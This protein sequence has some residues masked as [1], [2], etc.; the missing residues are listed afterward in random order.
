M[1]I[2]IDN[3]INL[4][5]TVPGAIVNPG[6][7][8]TFALTVP[9]G[10]MGYLYAQATP[11]AGS[12]LVPQISLSDPALVDGYDLGSYL[13]ITSFSNSSETI[14]Y[15]QPVPVGQDST[16]GLL[17]A[18]GG[19]TPG[20]GNLNP[21]FTQFLLPGTYF[22]TVAA[23]GDGTSTGAYT[24]TT[25]FTLA[26]SDPFVSQFNQPQIVTAPGPVAVIAAP[27]R[28]NG[29]TDLVTANDAP[30]GAS[31]TVILGDGDGTFQAA[32]S[33]PIAGP[34]GST[35]NLTD[36]VASDYNNDGRLSL[37]TY[38]AT[39]GIIYVLPGLGDGTFLDTPSSVLTLNAASNP[40]LLAL[41]ASGPQTTALLP[42]GQLPDVNRD[43][44]PDTITLVSQNHNGQAPYTTGLAESFGVPGTVTGNV[45]G[46]VSFLGLFSFPATVSLSYTFSSSFSV[47]ANDGKVPAGIDEQTPLLTNVTGH[48]PGDLAQ[49]EL[50][51]DQSG[52]ILLRQG[53]PDHPGTFEAPLTINDP[54]TDPARAIAVLATGANAR[55]AAIGLQDRIA[56]YSRQLD[57]TWVETPGPT[58]QAS[59]FPSTVIL[60]VDLNQDGIPD[61][62]VP[63]PLLGTVDVYLGRADGTF[64]STPLSFKT[65]ITVSNVTA[66]DVNGDN[67]MDLI[68]TDP[69]SGDVSVLLNQGLS[70][71]QLG[72]QPAV[73]YRAGGSSYG[74]VDNQFASIF[75]TQATSLGFSGFLDPY[76]SQY[77]VYSGEQTIAAATGNFSGPN[78]TDLVT[79]N[80]GTNTIG[81]LLAQPGPQGNLEASYA[82]PLVFSSGGQGPTA[83]VVAPLVKGS[84]QDDV[85][86]LNQ[87]SDSIAVYLGNGQGGFT[88]STPFFTITAGNGATGITVADVNGDGIP[89]L[90]IGNADGDVLTLIGAGDGTFVPLVQ[91]GTDIP[92]AVTPLSATQDDIILANPV[93]NQVA[94]QSGLP[95]NAVTNGSSGTLVST[96][97][98]VFQNAQD[99]IL[100]PGAVQAANLIPGDPYPALIVANSGGN[101]VFVYP[102]TGPGQFDVA[103]AQS[104]AVGTDPVSVTVADVNGD[105]T[106]DL[107]VADKGS[108]DVAILL[109]QGSGSSWTTIKGERLSSGGNGPASTVVKDVNGDGISDILVTNSGSNNVALLPGVGGGFFNDQNPTVF[110]TGPRP[111]QIVAVTTATGS[112]FVV[113]NTGGSTLTELSDFTGGQFST[114][115]N[116]D[117]GGFNPV[118]L[119]AVDLDLPG[120]LP[121]L[122]DLI[123]AD[124]NTGDLFTPATGSDTGNLT[125]LV[126]DDTGFSVEETFTDPNMPNPSAVA[127]S[128][129]DEGVFYATT[130]GV[131]QAFRFQIDLAPPQTVST[132]QPV[133]GS[134]PVAFAPA[135]VPVSAFGPPTVVPV[136]NLAEIAEVLTGSASD[137]GM[138]GSALIGGEAGSNP[139]GI[140]RSL[141]L[142]VSADGGK[143][144]TNDAWRRLLDDL[145]EAHETWAGNVVQQ[146]A[147]AWRGFQESVLDVD[148]GRGALVSNT[149]HL[150]GV[151]E[152]NLPDLQWRADRQSAPGSRRGFGPIHLECHGSRRNGRT[153]PGFR[154]GD[155]FTLAPRREGWTPDRG[156]AP[157]GGARATWQGIGAALPALGA[158]ELPLQDTVDA[159]SRS[160]LETFRLAPSSPAAPR[161]G[162]SRVRS[163]WQAKAGQR[164]SSRYCSWKASAAATGC[165]TAP[166]G[167]S[168]PLCG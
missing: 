61:L 119:V 47:A 135:V 136:T 162:R 98:T 100:A 45:N 144:T 30:G 112:G 68:A 9:A 134:S 39:A 145:D 14:N 56:I 41:F 167:R 35:P 161:P 37:L 3:T 42:N 138:L 123:V 69:A 8:D 113:V 156:S 102:G 147:E 99:G 5:G 166:F 114:D 92:L 31:L 125:L 159:V 124:A 148:S 52:A 110:A 33:Y 79:V 88:T 120:A 27:L 26:A 74:E 55:I 117:A 73:L 6:D 151:N 82:N 127:L 38:D 115:R 94:T 149:G 67:R 108:N 54:T 70:G 107:V 128:A 76:P 50:V 126:G 16:T 77:F 91:P 34:A 139:L 146:S 109:G 23:G 103:T 143:G 7:V 85:V 130:D 53:V 164:R 105:G 95:A 32:V 132:F 11:A 122:T 60:A 25:N 83:V 15:S 63:N 72:F 17:V 160:L 58:L 131:E 116:I 87:D 64:V 4:T 51:V 141:S 165:S 10:E 21:N 57:G 90:L 43:G 44:Y 59:P 71:G 101:D 163:S 65:G 75:N 111:G 155:G 93:A 137:G 19:G 154:A 18:S 106:P 20:S 28:N 12:P 133:E 36:V 152:L 153:L 121:G 158:S 168:G 49:D 118:A 129:V 29:I 150:L 48:A 96:A 22:I 40:N 81:L 13:A 104:F 142:F 62:V 140:E 1:S 157:A 46:V 89:D 66:A 86:V 80:R 97:V 84:T 2:Q 24:L 78:S